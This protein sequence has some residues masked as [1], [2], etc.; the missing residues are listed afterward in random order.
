MLGI[1]KGRSLLEE[2]IQLQ[3]RQI[4]QIDKD[5]GDKR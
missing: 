5:E 1:D 2:Y 4:K 3:I